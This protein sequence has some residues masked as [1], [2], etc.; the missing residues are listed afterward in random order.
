MRKRF[1][2]AGRRGFT[3]VELLVVIAILAILASLLVPAVRAMYRSADDAKC[4]ANLKYWATNIH[5]GKQGAELP[6]LAQAGDPLYTASQVQAFF[7][8]KDMSPKVAYP[9]ASRKMGSNAESGTWL[10]MD[11]TTY[12]AP[13]YGS[14]AIIDDSQNIGG[15]PVP[16]LVD[17][18]D[19]SVEIGGTDVDPKFEVVS[20]GSAYHE[21]ANMLRLVG[22]DGTGSDYVKWKYS[23][24]FVDGVTYT[25]KVEVHFVMYEDRAQNIPYECSSNEGVKSAQRVSQRGTNGVTKWQELKDGT[26]S[27]LTFQVAAGTEYYVKVSDNMA[28]GASDVII[29]DAVRITPLSMEGG[30]GGFEVGFRTLSG[31]WTQPTPGEAYPS[32]NPSMHRCDMTTSS[33]TAEWLFPMVDAGLYEVS[34]WWPAYSDRKSQVPYTIHYG[35]GVDTVTVNQQEDGAQWNVLGSY[36]FN[37]ETQPK[38]TLG[39]ATGSGEV[40]VADAVRIAKRPKVVQSKS[41]IGYLWLQERGDLPGTLSE[42]TRLFPCSLYQVDDASA[43]PMLVDW[44]TPEHEQYWTH[45]D[46]GGHI[47]YLDG[48]VD[49]LHTE[50]TQLRWIDDDPNGTLLRFYW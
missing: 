1:N 2:H 34:A 17:N 48:R 15:L 20:P 44:I 8:D 27:T 16:I 5:L 43:V 19:V 31:I 41:V 40:V 30:G 9:P 46:R 45:P 25:V 42:G 3:L 33:G 24:P 4:V 38:V 14:A 21:G 50:D 11:I 7:E 22:A 39:V 6:V 12:T 18:S 37:G 10:Q 26:G 35:G 29:A 13:D 23:F 36:Y 32:S 49:F 28:G 47:L